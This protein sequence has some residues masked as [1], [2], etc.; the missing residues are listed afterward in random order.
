M[1][2][3]GEMEP[4]NHFH[5][6]YQPNYKQILAEVFINGKLNPHHI[7]RHRL[8]AGRRVIVQKT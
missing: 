4:E 5:Q 1:D 8:H 2:F 3:S 6:N 7:K